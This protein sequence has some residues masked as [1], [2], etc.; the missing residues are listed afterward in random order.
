[1]YVMSKRVTLEPPV[2][3]ETPYCDGS[4]IVLMPILC[5]VSST[6]GT[7]AKSAAC[8]A[9]ELIELPSAVRT[10]IGPLKLRVG[11][12]GQNCLGSGGLGQHFGPSTTMVPGL[13]PLR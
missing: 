9:A 3:I 13:Q 2:A 8:T 10:G 1:M 12:E 5:A 7:V 4:G 11:P 6:Q